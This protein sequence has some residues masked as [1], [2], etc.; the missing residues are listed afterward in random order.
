MGIGHRV[1]TQMYNTIY[2]FQ[3]DEMQKQVLDLITED[4][5]SP[6]KRKL[7]DRDDT[8]EFALSEAPTPKVQ[9]TID[10]KM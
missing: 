6:K 10:G 1:T 3:D 8:E 7:N 9:M 2:L 5:N 4:S